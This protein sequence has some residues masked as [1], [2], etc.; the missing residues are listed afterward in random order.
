MVSSRLAA[1]FVLAFIGQNLGLTV[2]KCG[3]SIIAYSPLGR[4]FLTGKYKSADDFEEG[5]FRKNNPRFSKEVNTA[6]FASLK[7]V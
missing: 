5:D 3:V 4:G 7:P 6:L 1:R 2:I